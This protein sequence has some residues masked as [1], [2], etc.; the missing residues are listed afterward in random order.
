M[1][2]EMRFFLF[3]MLPKKLARV[4]TTPNGVEEGSRHL[5]VESFVWAGGPGLRLT[6]EATAVGRDCTGMRL[7]RRCDWRQDVI[8]DKMWLKIRC[9]WRKDANIDAIEEKM[10]LKIRCDWRY[11]WRKRCVWRRSDCSGKRLH[12]DAIEE[13]MWLKTRCDWR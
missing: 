7:K 8:E 11:Y 2:L 1:Q 6:P 12:R 3:I 13:E 4:T 10:Q 9:D 5:V